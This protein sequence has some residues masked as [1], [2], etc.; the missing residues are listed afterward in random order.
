MTEAMLKPQTALK[1]D[2][3]VLEEGRVELQ[4]PFPRGARIVVFVIEEAGDRFDDLLL[5]AQSNLDFWDNPFD[6]E[7]WNNA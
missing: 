7:D 1:Y 3:E 5:A 2:V 6:D 4:V